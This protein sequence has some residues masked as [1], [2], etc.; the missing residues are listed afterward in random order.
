MAPRPLPPSPAL[1]LSHAAKVGSRFHPNAG[2]GHEA[3][4]PPPTFLACQTTEEDLDPRTHSTWRRGRYHL[5]PLSRSHTPPRSAPA[6]TP[7]RGVAMRRHH[8]HPRSWLAKR[9]RR[10][11]TRG[12]TAHGAEAATTF[13]RSPALTRRQGRLPLSPQRGVWP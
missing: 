13:S 12:H 11:W 10:T 1:P 2:C 7:T 5:L 3:S 9:Q 4:P 8:P 6:F